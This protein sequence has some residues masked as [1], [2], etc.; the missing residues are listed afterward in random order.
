LC[1]I[2]I[3]ERSLLNEITEENFV[4]LLRQRA[5]QILDPD[6]FMKIAFGIHLSRKTTAKFDKKNAPRIL[7]LSESFDVYY[8]P[9]IRGHSD[10]INENNVGKNGT[11]CSHIF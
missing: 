11:F 7:N 1:L 6:S 5:S 4:N 8:R 10:F 9:K 2:K 3:S